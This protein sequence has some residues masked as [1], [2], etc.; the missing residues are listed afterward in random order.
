MLREAGWEILDTEGDIQ[1]SKACIEIEVHGMPNQSKVGY[2]D[3]VLF[4]ADGKPL[5]VIE[6]KRT[7]VDPEKVG[8]RPNYT[9]NVSK[10]IRRTACNILYQRI[11]GQNH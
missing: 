8:I 2:A 5:A 11:F 4:G 10:R 3:Y 9:P 1:P 6:A 7:S